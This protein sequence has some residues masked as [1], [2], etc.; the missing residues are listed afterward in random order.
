MTRYRDGDHDGEDV[1]HW[2]EGVCDLCQGTTTQTDTDR[3]LSL[4]EGWLW[5][6]KEAGHHD[7]RH[8]CPTCRYQGATV[9]FLQFGLNPDKF[10]VDIMGAL[11]QITRIA[12]NLTQY[13]GEARIQISDRYGTNENNKPIWN[14]LTNMENLISMFRTNS[15]VAI[16]ELHQFGK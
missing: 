7:N 3:D 13:L 10:G 5:V 16:G 11:A 9:K 6:G 2:Q 4:P 14:T 15:E 8:V 12:D 1:T